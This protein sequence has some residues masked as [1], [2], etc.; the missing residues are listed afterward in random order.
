MVL[1]QMLCSEERRQ[2]F[3][4]RVAS[5][6]ANLREAAISEY[7]DHWHRRAPSD[8]PPVDVTFGPF[9]RRFFTSLTRTKSKGEPRRE[10]R[11]KSDLGVGTT[12]ATPRAKSYRPRTRTLPSENSVPCPE[13]GDGWRRETHRRKT[14]NGRNRPGE[15]YYTYIAPD[16]RKLYSKAAAAK[17]VPQQQA[18]QQT[19]RDEKAADVGLATDEM[20]VDGITFRCESNEVAGP[21][22]VHDGAAE[23]LEAVEVEAVEVEALEASSDVEE[24]GEW[25]HATWVNATVVGAG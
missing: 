21:P 20:V 23:Q 11:A 17:Y 22:T 25:H 6:S 16:L 1:R 14:G 19:E 18:P 5:R 4:A 10:R 9:D 3:A 12:P 24:G 7:L 15:V 8:Y 13:L 2:E